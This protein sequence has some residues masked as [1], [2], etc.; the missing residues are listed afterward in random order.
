MRYTPLMISRLGEYYI[1]VRSMRINQKTVPL[2]THIGGT[3]IST[4][5]PYT[6]LERSIYQSFTQ[7][8]TDQLSHISQIPPVAPFSV[9]YDSRKFPNTIAGPG[10]PKIDLVLGDQSVVW[11]IFGANSMMQAQ[12]GVL[13]LGFLD[14]GLHT[15]DSIVIGAYQL[16][17]NLV[18]FDLYD[19]RL[20]CHNNTCALTSGNPV[21]QEIDTGELAQDVLS[22]RSIRVKS[23]INPSASGPVV[24]V[25]QFLFVCA[26]PTLLKNGLPDYVEGVVGLGQTSI[27]LPTQLAS[28]F[29]FRPNFALCLTSSFR[30][31]GFIYFGDD[32]STLL[33][34][35]SPQMSYTPLSVGRQGDQFSIQHPQSGGAPPVGPFSVCFDP[36]RIS[37]TTGGPDFPKVDLVVG[38]QNVAWTL[39]GANSMVRV[40]P[41]ISCL[42]FIDGG[43]NPADSIVIGAHQLE[44]NLVHFDLHN[45][46][47]GFSSSL[48]NRKTSCS[49]RNNPVNP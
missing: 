34:N 26:P 8:F 17:D 19:S 27:A 33:P 2:Q 25:P 7:I 29:G 4:T 10:V 43:L 12:L 5:T 40:H 15:R 6:V 35:V 28:H 38:D 32:P 3:M 21:S 23:S 42:A 1:D 18:D 48:F 9:C 22:I 41:L 14:G 16:E 49:N 13:C 39:F 20:G 37:D 44:E 24:K 46:K 11:T 30:S 31:P 36:R 45:S 47:I